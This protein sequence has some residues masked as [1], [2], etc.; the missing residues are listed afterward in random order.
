[1]NLFVL[2][3]M[4]GIFTFLYVLFF[5]IGFLTIPLLVFFFSVLLFLVLKEKRWIKVALFLTPIFPALA[6]FSPVKY[7]YNYF[8]IPLL[9]FG[10]GILVGIFLKSEFLGNI[11]DA[12]KYFVYVIFLSSL[13]VYARWTNITLKGM[14]FLKDTPVSPAGER[15]SFG[16]IFPLI[17]ILTYTTFSFVFNVFKNSNGEEEYAHFK[18]LS[19]GYMISVL[20]AIL[21][22]MDIT[23]TFACGNCLRIKQFNGMFSD[24]NGLGTFSGILFFISIYMILR[25]FRVFPLLTMFF[26]LFGSFVSGSRSSFLLITIGVGFF[27]VKVIVL[28]KKF[29][30]GS[31][32]ILVV[33]FLFF[34][35]GGSVKKRVFFSFKSLKAKDVSIWEKFDRFSN[36]RITMLNFGIK[37]VKEFP[38]SGIGAGN[39]L[40]Y[41]KYKN[42]GKKF[43]YDLP[44]NQYLLVLE[45]TGI[46]G[47]VFFVYFLYY[48]FVGTRKKLL[49]SSILFIFLFNTA[50]WL[51]EIVVIFAFFSGFGF[52]EKKLNVGGIVVFVLFS[53]FVLFNVLSFEKLHPANWLKE[54]GKYYD[55]GFWY[56]EKSGSEVYRWTKDKAGIYIN[57]RRLQNKFSNLKIFCGAP[58]SYFPG[59]IQKVKIYWRGKLYKEIIFTKNSFI[60]VGIAFNGKKGFLEFSVEPVFNLKKMK[61]GSE[62]RTL[63]VQVYGF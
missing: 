27:L 50:L 56:E 5:K 39:Y 3:Y 41:L 33:V 57:S 21:Q 24:F 48:V 59:R 29:V 62:P 10:G 23:K 38:V 14:A 47:F 42:Y 16:V 32:L 2:I 11:P 51:P 34:V 36:R 37:T 25:K 40:F 17:N 63:G 31:L 60:N 12:L 35:F 18:A 45:E 46:I 54:K 58:L 8:L 28:K 19:V 30:L 22:K 6:F 43:L 52:N 49:F 26:S 7:P 15:L 13:F 9:F 53:A 4:F 55:Y 44:L 1:M 61:L 20:I